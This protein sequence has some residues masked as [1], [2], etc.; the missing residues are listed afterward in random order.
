MCTIQKQVTGLLYMSVFKLFFLLLFSSMSSLSA[1]VIDNNHKQIDILSQASIFIDYERQHTIQDIVTKH[2]R[3]NHE[4]ILSFGYSPNFDVW[5]KFTLTN[6][7]NQHLH[8]ILEYD[9]ALTTHIELY[10][11]NNL[12]KVQKDGLFMLNLE[13]KTI[14]PNFHI[15]LNPK[16]HKT[17][18]VK[19]SSEITTLIVKLKLWESSTLYEKEI[20][21]QVILSLFFGAMIILALYNL[22]IYFFTKDISYLFYVLY[23]VGVIIHHM[24]FVGIGNIYVLNQTLIIKIITFA[25]ILSAFPIFALGL[26]TKTFLQTKQYPLLNRLLNYFLFLLP[27]SVLFFSITQE[28]NSYRNIISVCMIVYLMIVAIYATL[29]YNRQA[30][31]VLFGEIIIASAFTSMYLSSA[32]IF[33]LYEYFPYFVETALVLEAIIFSIALA[34][35]I[36]QLQKDKNEASLQ[37]IEQQANEKER[38]AIQVA[39]KTHDLKVAL[40]EKGLLLKELN[41]RVKNNM[42]TIVSLIRLQS[43]EVKNEKVKE[44]FIT[45]QNRINAMSHLHELLYKQDNIA[46]VNAYEYFDVLIDELKESYDNNITIHF[47]IQTNLKMEQAVY[48]GLILNELVTNSFKYAFEHNDGNINIS[49]TCQEDYYVFKISDDGKGYDMTQP[50]TS[51]GLTLVETLAKHQLKGSLHSH[52]QNGV[53]VTV[54]W[55]NNE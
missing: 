32:G 16:E 45:I 18:Y 38:L 8:K 10:E 17:F 19:A 30:Y 13:R 26:F 28:Y 50:N 3:A 37:L 2:F 21:H 6:D 48:C 22:F 9:N 11:H 52:T 55:K 54:K 27:L 33:N 1:I 36:K 15:H 46:Y 39:N 14:K 20:Q 51:L 49:L 42:Q 31:F 53:E 34:D 40:D 25:S 4:P 12:E 44:L 29:K 41:H 5:I 7:T 43:D 24:I 35:K 47:D 23:I